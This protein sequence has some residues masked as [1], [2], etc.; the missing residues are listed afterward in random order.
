MSVATIAVLVAKDKSPE[1]PYRDASGHDVD[2]AITDEY[3]IAQVYHYV[4]LHTAD[5]TRP[6]GQPQVDTW[7]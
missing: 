6:V 1:Y 5:C 3:M 2:L 4:M 7:G